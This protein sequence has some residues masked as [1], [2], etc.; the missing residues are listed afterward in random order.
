MFE[1]DLNGPKANIAELLVKEG[2]ACFKEGSEGFS[3]CCCNVTCCFR[4]LLVCN[5]QWV[6]LSTDLRPKMPFHLL[7]P[8]LCGTPR[9]TSGQPPVIL[10]PRII[11]PPVSAKRSRWSLSRRWSSLP[12]WKRFPSESATLT[13]PAASTSSSPRATHSW[14]G[15]RVV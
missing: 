3:L 11:K 13:P 9:L 6:S 15:Q 14:A 8:A 1:S 5:S 10:T 4:S 7:M 12:S 2:L